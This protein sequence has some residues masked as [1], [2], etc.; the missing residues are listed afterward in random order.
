MRRRSPSITWKWTR[1]VSPA[2]NCG[3]PS[4]S[5]ARSSSS[6]IL[7]IREPAGG[8]PAANGSSHH[9]EA[10]GRPVD[11]EHLA[12]DVPPRHRAPAARVARRRAVVS[13]H[14]VVVLRDLPRGVR[15]EVATVPLDVRL[16]QALAVDEDAPLALL[17]DV[18]RQA[19]DALHE[20]AA[21]PAGRLRRARHVEDDDLAAVRIAKV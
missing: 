3:I 21:G 9:T 18:A 11:R 14:E 20:D 7:L 8:R 1:T 16:V 19:D 6:M 15:L 2:L 13:H 17:P 4:R 12:D 5:C 10:L